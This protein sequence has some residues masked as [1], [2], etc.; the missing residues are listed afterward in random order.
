MGRKTGKSI[1]FIQ[2]EQV[3]GDPLPYESSPQRSRLVG[4]GRDLSFPCG[5]R[6]YK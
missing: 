5:A 3:S 2:G 1:E 6:G 4:V